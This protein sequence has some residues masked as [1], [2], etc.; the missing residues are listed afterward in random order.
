MS[1][2]KKYKLIRLTTIDGSLWVLLK[3]QLRFL[4]A[5]FEVV[6]VAD[7]SGRLAQVAEREGVRTVAVPMRREI[8]LLNDVQSLI[9]LIRLFRKEKPYIVH[10]NTPKASLL[11]M[12]AARITGVPHRIYLVTGLRFETACGLFRWV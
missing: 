2:S 11:G 12:L 1:M 9:L 3:G 5:E 10:A 6:G 4:S 8:S 7:D